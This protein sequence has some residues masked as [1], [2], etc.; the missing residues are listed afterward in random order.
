[1]KWL[2][3]NDKNGLYDPFGTI[4]KI[5]AAENANSKKLGCPEPNFNLL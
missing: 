3:V 1:M 5:L 4:L 2:C